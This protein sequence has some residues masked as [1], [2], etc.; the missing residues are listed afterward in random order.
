MHAA[1]CLSNVVVIFLLFLFQLV[2]CCSSNIFNKPYIF[3]RNIGEI[4]MILIQILTM[5]LILKRKQRT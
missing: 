3:Q 5:T 4:I 2:F 1:A